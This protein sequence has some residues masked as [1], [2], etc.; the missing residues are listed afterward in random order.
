MDKGIGKLCQKGTYSTALNSNPNCTPCPDGITTANE[1]STAATDCSL[2]LKGY[3]IDANDATK[4]V[5]CPLDTYQDQEAA[6][7]NCTACPNG[8]KTKE[9]GATG[10]ALCLAPPGYELKDG[11]TTITACAAGSYKADWNRNAC[12][13]VSGLVA[14]SFWMLM[15]SESTSH[16]AAATNSSLLLNWQQQ[17]RTQT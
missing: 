8:W 16:C 14:H 3:Y 11:A 17:F 13:A 1:G 6:V 15:P 10:V 9:T 5:K 2:A 12:V 4:A 7:N